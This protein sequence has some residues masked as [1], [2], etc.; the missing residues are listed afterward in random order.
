MSS[1]DTINVCEIFASIQGESTR[2]GWPCVFI[3]LAGCNL[4]CNWC[5]TTYAWETGED[6]T[7]EDILAQTAEYGI[8]RVEV[9]GGEPLTQPKTFELLSQ[10]IA[11]GNEVL[12]ETNG[13][14]DIS[15]VDPKVVRIVDV[16]CPSSGVSDENLT[17]NYEN[18]TANDEVKFVIADRDDFD[19]A[20]AIL[21]EHNLIARCVVT[22][23]PVSDRLALAKLAEWI[24]ADGLDVR[25]G[26]QLHKIIWPDKDRG[27]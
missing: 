6:M 7:I 19:F 3:R 2:A 21:T 9:T 10:L 15:A 12:L 13:S 16:K 4:R 25:L 24:L 1:K 8:P 14:V 27:V 26:L 5:D 11:A 18:L 17:A 23:S 22:F 20:V